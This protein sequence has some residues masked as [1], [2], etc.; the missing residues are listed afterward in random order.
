MSLPRTFTLDLDKMFQLLNDSEEFAR[1]SRDVSAVFSFEIPG[2]THT[3][4][5]IPGAIA[6]VV[7]GIPLTGNDFSVAG[8]IEGWRGILDGS[9]HLFWATNPFHGELEV[10]GDAVLMAGS[11]R[12]VFHVCSELQEVVSDG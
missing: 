4:R 6:E 2:H 1:K 7:S 12:T 9:M 3:Y 5:V 11:M 10:K 8:P